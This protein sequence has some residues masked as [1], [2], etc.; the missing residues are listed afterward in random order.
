MASDTPINLLPPAPWQNGCQLSQALGQGEQ[1]A[2]AVMSATYARIRALNPTLN[3][4]VSLIDEEQAMAMAQAA[5]T[6]APAQRG[7]L[8]GIPFAPKDAVV[9]KGFATTWGFKPYAENIAKADDELARRLRAAGAL[10]IGRTNMPEFGLGSHTFNDIYGHTLNPYDLSKTPG[11]SSGGAAVALAADLLP[12]ADGSD[13]GGSLRNPASFCNVVGFRPSIGRM[14]YSRG[15]AWFGRMVTTGPMA[16][17]VSD[18]ALLLSVMAGPDARDPLTLSEPGSHFRKALDRDV[19]AKNLRVAVSPDLGALPIDP[20]VIQTV[21]NAATVL[22]NLGADVVAVDPPLQ[23]AMEV[24][25]TQRAAGLRLLAMGLERSVPNWRKLVKDTAL[26]NMQKGL[27]LS[28]DELMNSELARSHIYENMVNFFDE[29]D[30]L[31]LPA[32]QVPPFDKD[33]PWV[34][35]INGVQMQ[36]YIDWMAACCMVSV[37]GLPCVSVPG[38]FSNCGLPIGVQLVGKPRG[39]LELLRIAHL[40]EQANHG[41][42]RKPDLSNIG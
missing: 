2:V 25:Q 31:V 32:A 39:D 11:G 21:N 23:G 34:K 10:F 13:L 6:V 38:G 40:F 33:L 17:N 42:N 41:A 1:S 28:A 8:H 37:T 26:W 7:P 36:T 30:V 29:Y 16:K 4:I 12:F 3:A 14:P 35:E 5:D 22:E 20:E 24:F 18:L 27:D 15:Y 19:D 9:V